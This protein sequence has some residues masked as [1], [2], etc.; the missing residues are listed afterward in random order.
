MDAGSLQD[1]PDGVHQKRL[2]AWL[3]PDSV[4]QQAFDA[5]TFRFA[6][7]A[8]TRLYFPKNTLPPPTT[9][10]ICAQYRNKLRP[11]LLLVTGLQQQDFMIMSPASHHAPAHA[12]ATWSLHLI[13]V[14]Y[15][16]EPLCQ[17][18]IAA[19]S[20]QHLSLAGLLKLAGWSLVPLTH[21]GS[22]AHPVTTIPLGSLGSIFSVLPEALHALAVP[23]H[24]VHHALRDLSLSAIRSA[25]HL[26]TSY[27]MRIMQD[28]DAPAP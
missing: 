19:K 21:D 4:I 22:P 1:L 11:D 20:R 17:S 12:R 23:T 5:R 7:G 2:P 14:G 9:P 16:T 28:R 3:L 8:P 25:H 26:L 18:A 10:A 27:R 15:H 6:P 24:E 13:E